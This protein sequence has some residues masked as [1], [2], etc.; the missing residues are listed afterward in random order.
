MSASTAASHKRSP[1]EAVIRAR[2]D[3]VVWGMTAL[4]LASRLA[5][6][7][8]YGYFRDELYYIACS[9]HLDWGYV[10]QPP[11]VALVAWI[12]RHALGDS[13]YS[14]RLFPALAAAAT[15]LLTGLIARELGGGRFAILLSCIAVCFS[16]YFFATYL[17]TDNFMPLA[18]TGCA[19]VAIRIFKGGNGKLWLLFG[20]IAG[21]GFE[22]KHAFLFFGSAFVLGMILTRERRWMADKWIWLGGAI[23]LLLALPNLVWE[24]QHDWATLELLLNVARSDKNVVLG[25]A[26]FL[27]NQL[28]LMNPLTAPLWIAGLAWLFVARDREWQRVLA[29]TY[30]LMYTLFFVLHGKNYYLS[31][32]YPYLFAAGAVATERWTEKHLRWLRIA[33]VSA[34]AVVGA[35]LAPFAAGFLPVET[36]IAYQH[37]LHLKVP[38]TEN[39]QLGSLPQMYADMF[40]WPELA[41]AVA[42]VYGRLTPEEKSECP[43]YAQNYG[44]AG[45]IDFFGGRY[46]LPKAVSGHQNYFLW[47]P[48]DYTGE[49]MI[50]IDD[51]ERNRLSEDFES[52]QLAG[53]F[54]SEY[55]M[56]YENNRGIF[57]C[58]GLKGGTL[59]RIWPRL[60]KWI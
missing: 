49:L 31:P 19:L 60:K 55:V 20:A 11:L 50:V 24:Y 54:H 36:F 16:P 30:V 47:G 46:G 44:E 45:A 39:N 14:I 18:W 7:R 3:V 37:A 51:P 5:T 41:K 27:W 58:R 48:R 57:I 52:V 28:L 53:T 8:G 12:E 4:T 40:G 9:E 42:N 23:A 6:L 56:P 43:I 1:N 34:V 13:I 32:I 10:D 59:Q 22:G 29:W 38:E 2:V 26:S 33:S 25:P 21:L 17:V 35:L 15:V